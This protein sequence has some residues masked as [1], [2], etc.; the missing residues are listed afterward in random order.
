MCTICCKCCWLS[1]R[2]CNFLYV[3]RLCKVRLR[4]SK[5]LALCLALVL[6][7]RIWCAS[8]RSLVLCGVGSMD[9]YRGVD[10]HKN[11]ADY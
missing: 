11:I 4:A 1:A 5:E 6:G 9:F 7:R 3:D 8:R 10:E 2:V